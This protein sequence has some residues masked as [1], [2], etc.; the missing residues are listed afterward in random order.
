MKRS[1]SDSM[2]AAAAAATESKRLA[3]VAGRAARHA[4]LAVFAITA[5]FIVGLGV[6]R[7]FLL[8]AERRVSVE[9]TRVA[10]LAQRLLYLDEKL[11]MSAVMA[12]QTGD[13]QW[14]TRWELALPESFRVI[15]EASRLAPPSLAL[16][17]ER[18]ASVA[19]DA[20]VQLEQEVFAH[21]AAGRLSQ[22]QQSLNGEL[23]ASHKRVLE[24]TTQRFLSGLKAS[25]DD[26]ARAERAQSRWIV[27]GL[28]LGVLLGFVWLWR[29]VS[30]GLLEAEGAL[31]QQQKLVSELAMTDALT[32]LPNRASLLATLQ[33]QLRR[34]SRDGA[35]GGFA[36]LAMDLDRFK[37]INDTY[38]HEAGDQVLMAVAERLTQNRRGD[39]AAR[40]GGDEFVVL[41]QGADAEAAREK[42]Q[43]LIVQ[44][45]APVLLADGAVRVGASFGIAIAPIHGN[46]S[47][48]LMHHADLALLRA[49]RAGRQLACV[50]DPESPGDSADLGRY[51]FMA[52]LERD[53]GLGRVVAFAQPLVHLASGRVAGF[54]LLA[55]WHHPERGLLTPDK[56]IPL[57]DEVG[58]IDELTLELLRQALAQDECRAPGRVLALNLSGRQLLRPGLADELVKLLQERGMPSSAL[59]VEVSEQSLIDDLPRARAS[60]ARMRE[61]GIRIALDDF[62][63]GYSSLT[64]LT[65]L[66]FD[67]IKIDRSFVMSRDAAGTNAQIV[68]AVL[69]L[70]ASLGVPATAEGIEAEAVAQR[71]RS[72]GC[73]MGQGYWYSPPKPLHEV[74]EMVRRLHDRAGPAPEAVGTAL[75]VVKA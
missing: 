71:L 49:K 12:A 58:L 42:A 23:Y 2:P 50:F 32:G 21:V 18:E 72:L 62:G 36:V 15:E 25:V 17:F 51:A 47:K 55:R 4:V 48:K 57:A 44:L 59:E 41:L 9:Q 8:L 61:L 70:G 56:F 38:G 29:R 3:L 73:E 7:T 19:N 37:P 45:S 67:R 13:P 14:V 16:Q 52:E 26:R 53:L 64:H 6:E 40:M 28:V 33:M 30:Q 34:S 66:C 46:D 39:V 65:E 54:E 22:A 1:F 27:S 68:Q 63:T 60:L 11:T 35:A 75:R 31:L 43:R 24:D 5:L 74:P 69:A 20:L 10:E